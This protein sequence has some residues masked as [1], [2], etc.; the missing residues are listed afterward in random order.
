MALLQLALDL[1]EVMGVEVVPVRP[2]LRNDKFLLPFFDGR[3]VSFLVI[4]RWGG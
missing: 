4:R 3:A 1:V 2:A